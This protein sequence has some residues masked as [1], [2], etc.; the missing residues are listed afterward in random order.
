MDFTNSP[1]HVSLSSRQ[2]NGPASGKYGRKEMKR[3]K[4]FFLG[5]GRILKEVN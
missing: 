3:K 2:H 4:L 1:L 5:G